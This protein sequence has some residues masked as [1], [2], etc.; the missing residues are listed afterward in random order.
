M[1]PSKRNML[2]HTY[3]VIIVT[4]KL[5]E[6]RKELLG[7]NVLKERTK[8]E[9]ETEALQT[10]TKY[11]VVSV[12]IFGYRI[13]A[14]YFHHPLAARSRTSHLSNLSIC[15]DLEP[16]TFTAPWLLSELMAN[17][18]PSMNNTAVRSVTLAVWSTKDEAR[19]TMLDVQARSSLS[20]RELDLYRSRTSHLYSTMAVV[21]ADGECHTVNNTAVRSVTLA[22]WS[23]RDEARSTMLDVQPHSSIS[24]RKPTKRRQ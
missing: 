11:S 3:V 5:A 13:P 1:V 24:S 16:H 12:A 22:V 17:A 19:S 21:R 8:Y 7:H 18:T 10:R 9:Y 6:R 15:S 2:S 20:S 4:C 23:R 14:G